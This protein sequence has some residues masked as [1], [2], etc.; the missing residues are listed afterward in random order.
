MSEE[1]KEVITVDGVEYELDS[2][3]DTSRHLLRQIQVCT[4][5]TSR[6]QNELQ[7][8]EVARVG[9]VRMLKEQLAA[10]APEKDS[11]DDE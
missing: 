7:R 3:S 10:D 6:L 11:S 4:T 5:E 1:E 8:S 2:L 9:F